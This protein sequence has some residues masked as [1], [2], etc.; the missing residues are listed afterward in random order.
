MTDVIDWLMAGWVGALA[1]VVLWIEVAVLCAASPAPLDRLRTLAPN[2]C[3]GSFLL[4]AVGL[5]LSGA[6]A[7][8]ILLLMAGSLVAHAIDMLTRLRG[9]AAGFSRRTE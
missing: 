6:G 1:F 2:A 7:G 3:A 4:I 5:A 8:P 9:Q